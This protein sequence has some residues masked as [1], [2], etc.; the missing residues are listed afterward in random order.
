MGPEDERE[1]GGDLLAGHF[2][3]VAF[4]EVREAG[5]VVEELGRVGLLL[6]L[7]APCGEEVVLELLLRACRA[8]ACRRRG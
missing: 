1:V 8:R 4:A 5:E 6:V 2:R 3:G 7:V